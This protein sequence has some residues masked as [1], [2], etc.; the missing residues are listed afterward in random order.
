MAGWQPWSLH[1]MFVVAFFGA[2][3]VLGGT[4]ILVLGIAKNRQFFGTHAWTGTW[5][6]ATYS[7]SEGTPAQRAIVIAA[8]GASIIGVVAAVGAGVTS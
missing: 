7:W 8:R 6:L 1:E 2:F 3:V 4:T 5:M